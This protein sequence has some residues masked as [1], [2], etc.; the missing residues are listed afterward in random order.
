MHKIQSFNEF[1]NESWEEVR[2]D[3]NK[4]AAGLCIVCDNRMLLVLDTK[5]NYLG[6]PKGKLEV[7]EDPLDGAIRETL[8]ETGLNIEKS[9]IKQ[10]PYVVHTYKKDGILKHQLIYFLVQLASISEIGLSHHELLKEKIQAKE[11]SWA[12]FLSPQ[13]SYP[14]MSDS[15]RIILDRHLNL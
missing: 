5:N 3:A 15:Q 8:E 11:I 10:E 13:D 9:M 1:I 7:N 4:T 2:D 14:N 12:G 6:I